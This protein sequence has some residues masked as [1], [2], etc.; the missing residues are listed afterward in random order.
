VIDSI[1]HLM[2]LLGPVEREQVLKELTRASN[3]FP[4]AKAEEVMGTIIKLFPRDR[5]WSVAELKGK[6]AEHGIE[7][8]PKEVYNAIGYL[9]RK[10]HIKRVGYGRYVID[11]VEIATSDDLGGAS[12]RH[13][14]EYRTCWVE[15]EGDR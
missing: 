1:K 6:I 9:N 2:S 3:F 12:T 10:G 11:G 8:K 5:A 14:D 7:A 15:V 4:P 13:E